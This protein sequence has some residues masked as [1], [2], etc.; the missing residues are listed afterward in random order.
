MTELEKIR[1][2]KNDAINKMEKEHQ[3]RMQKLNSIDARLE[4][5]SREETVALLRE[6]LNVCNISGGAEKMTFNL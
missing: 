6:A 4:N 3:D 2:W 5:A 1:S